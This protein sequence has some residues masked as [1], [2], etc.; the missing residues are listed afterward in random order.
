[1]PDLELLMR[2]RV[3]IKGEGR[4]ICYW[5]NADSIAHLTMEDLLDELRNNAGSASEFF[6]AST[7]THSVG[8]EKSTTSRRSATH[9]ITPLDQSFSISDDRST[10]STHSEFLD[11]LRERIFE[12]D[13][14][15]IGECNGHQ[16]FAGDDGPMV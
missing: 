7:S 16:S 6:L 13:S 1:M 8:D 2:G 10:C 12:E 15:H 11:F 9:S 3:H 4:M 14:D 5:V